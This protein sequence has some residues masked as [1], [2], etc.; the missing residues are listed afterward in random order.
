MF[1]AKPRTLA[2][3]LYNPQSNLNALLQAPQAA[4]Q[5]NTLAQLVPSAAPWQMQYAAP[6]W[7]SRLTRLPP[8][9]ES[10]FRA[11]AK[12]NH[13]PITADYDMRAY[14][15]H[16]NDPNMGTAVNPNDHRLHF[17]DTYKTP[18][19]Q[20]FSGESIYANPASR[21]P[22]WNDKDQLISADGRVLFDERA[23][24]RHR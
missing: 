3:L 7:Q 20:S 14:W 17:P 1:G 15:L 5:Q 11:W 8:A 21:P 10:Q 24:A 22:M 12:A 4:P 13:A 16:R 19:H 9:K 18:L 23:N 6:D 2:D